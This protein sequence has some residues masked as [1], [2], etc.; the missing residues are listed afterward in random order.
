M[1]F[2]NYCAKIGYERALPVIED[3]F[4]DPNPNVRRAA[5]EGLRVWTS[6]PYFKDHPQIAVSFLAT[7][8][9]DESEYV[10]KSAG[11]CLHDI[12]KKY[13]DL[14][15]EEIK[16]W[17]LSSKKVLQVCKRA[18]RSFF[19]IRPINNEN[20]VDVLRLDVFEYQKDYIESIEEC[21]KD[22]RM[23]AY[24]I[25][26]QSKALYLKSEPIGFF[27]YGMNSEGYLYL[28]RFMIDWKYQG[29]GYGKIALYLILDEL[30]RQFKNVKT[31]CLSVCESNSRAI[32][33]YKRAGFKM[34][35]YF[36]G[37]DPVM[38]FDY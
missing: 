38:A 9:D 25:K 6:R 27:M 3:W 21:L 14:V 8:C 30:H 28:D 4:A 26:W 22:M 10:R 11:N 13:P 12:A 31:V 7:H 17:D 23:D 29:R 18:F 1:S 16:T 37:N 15:A 20:V 19:T 32:A 2:D 33:F 35:A 36:D 24:G 34:T 5:S